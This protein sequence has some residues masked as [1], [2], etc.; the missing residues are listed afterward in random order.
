VRRVALSGAQLLALA[1]DG[2]VTVDGVALRWPDDDRRVLRY[3]AEA[4]AADA[5]S[6]PYLL[7]VLLDGDRLAGRI[8]CHEGPRDGTVEIG[9]VVAPALR[10]RGLGTALVGDFLAWLHE[11]GLRRVR[12]SVAPSNAAS[13]AVLAHF[14]FV[15][16]G[17]HEDDEDGREL[18]LEAPLPAP[19]GPGLS[20]WSAG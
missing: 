13:L 8:G 9:Y 15:V 18:E 11:Q 16:V 7:H 14:G 5:A 6:A 20:T 19:A 3:R 2:P 10:R 1:G 17:E 12:A 4:L